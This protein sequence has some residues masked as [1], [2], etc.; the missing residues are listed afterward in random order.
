M[1]LAEPKMQSTGQAGPEINRDLEILFGKATE[2]VRE[3]NRLR[4]TLDAL[5]GGAQGSP[6]ASGSDGESGGTGT[7]GVKM[8]TYVT[9][10]RLAGSAEIEN[11]EDAFTSVDPGAPSD[12]VSYIIR[13]G[14]DSTD[15]A[16][17][18]ALLWRT[19][20]GAA[21]V[22]CVEVDSDEDDASPRIV[23]EVIPASGGSFEYLFN[24]TSATTQGWFVEYLGYYSLT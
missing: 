14:I 11:T 16:D 10:V 21:E 4:S 3:A 17:V 5:T 24:N 12:A 6:P 13:F 8:P 22:P 23:Y 7:S 2:L 20:S 18:S 9:P 15:N 19:E 1:S